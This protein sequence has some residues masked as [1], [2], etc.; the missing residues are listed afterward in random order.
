MKT[1][2]SK[3]DWQHV[4]IAL[5]IPSATAGFEAWMHGGFTTK[6]LGV[7]L[8]AAGGTL[9]ALAKQWATSSSS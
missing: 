2:L 8:V 7:G 6:S 1:L 9:V 4:A 5:L 3:I